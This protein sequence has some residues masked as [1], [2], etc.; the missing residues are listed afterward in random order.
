MENFGSIKFNEFLF[1]AYFF[2]F[3]EK[4]YWDGCQ[5]L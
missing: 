4:Y 3:F 1:F 2:S 5:W